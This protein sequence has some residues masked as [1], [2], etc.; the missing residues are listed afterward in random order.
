MYRAQDIDDI[1]RLLEILPVDPASGI[2]LRRAGVW[3]LLLGV[4]LKL[5]EVADVRT[6]ALFAA[7]FL[8]VKVLP[9]L[10]DDSPTDDIASTQRASRVAVCV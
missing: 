10:P 2:D 4:L 7:S 3:V 9:R 8:L 1:G 6:A 5:M